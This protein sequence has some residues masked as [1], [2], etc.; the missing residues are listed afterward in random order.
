M[1]ERSSGRRWSGVNPPKEIFHEKTIAGHCHVVRFSN[2]GLCAAV[3]YLDME[4]PARIG[5]QGDLGRSGHVSWDIH[6]SESGDRMRGDSLSGD[7]NE[8]LRADHVHG[9][10]RQVR[11]G[12]EMA[13]QHVG[14][15]HVR[16][17]GDATQGRDDVGFRCLRAQVTTQLLSRLNSAW[18]FWPSR[19]TAL[20]RMSFSVSPFKYF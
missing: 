12:C 3:R 7:G 19:T 1:A 18:I 14:A 5:A 6:Q 15:R 10:L 16:A 20:A 17:V 9:E 11:S 4:Q 13:G 2:A 8:F